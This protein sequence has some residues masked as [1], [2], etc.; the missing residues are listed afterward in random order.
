MEYD[1]AS[2]SIDLIGEPLWVRYFK[3]KNVL[4]IIR[5]MDRSKKIKILISWRNSLFFQSIICVFK[6]FPKKKLF[7]R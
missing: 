1:A 6:V 5:L 7:K 2:A 4:S 3:K